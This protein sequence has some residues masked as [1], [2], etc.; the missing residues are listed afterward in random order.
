ML[1]QWLFVRSW[2]P[3]SRYRCWLLSCFGAEVGRGVVIK[4]GMRV[5]FPWKLTLGNYVWLGEEVWIDNL[6]PV[7]IGNHVCLSQGAYLC[8][9][10]HNWSSDTFDLIAHPITVED[11]A[12]V[13]AR[14]VVGPGV[15]IGEGAIVSLG[16]VATKDVP[17]SHIV[18]GSPARPV[19]RRYSDCSI[20][21]LDQRSMTGE[22]L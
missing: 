6:A 14:V 22:Q 16:S 13:C 4:P 3:G 17:P 20:V 18:S 2:L 15:V 7:R 19:K 10:S 5:K 12:W 9:G 8:T 1:V 21:G 11:R